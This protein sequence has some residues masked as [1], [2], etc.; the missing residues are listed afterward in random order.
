MIHVLPQPDELDRGYLGR[1]MRWNGFQKQKDFIDYLASYF[2]AR[3]ASRREVPLVLLLSRL[4]GSSVSNFVKQHTTMPFR[5]GITSYQPDLEHGSEQSRSMLSMSAMRIARPGAYFCMHCVQTDL[6]RT[7]VTYWRRSWQLP[8]HFICLQHQEP[9]HYVGHE[10]AFLASPADYLFE[11][12]QVPAAWMAFL[13]TT[14]AIQRFIDIADYLMKRPN[15]LDVRDVSCVL[16]VQ[17]DMYGLQTYVGSVKQSLLS[18]L[19]ASQFDQ[20]WLQE[21]FHELLGKEEGNWFDPIDGVLCKKTSASS[22]IAYVLAAAVLYPD[23]RLA[24]DALA[25]AKSAASTLRRGKRKVVLNAIRLREAYIEERGNH[26]GVAQ[27]F[28]SVAVPTVTGRLNELGLPNL[29]Q[30][31]SRNQKLFNGLMA[32]LLGGCPLSEAAENAGVSVSVLETLLRRSSVGL[33]QALQAMPV[34]PAEVGDNLP[35]QSVARTQLEKNSRQK[36]STGKRSSYR[37]IRRESLLLNA[38]TAS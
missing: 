1:A 16:K 38:S 24:I 21:V 19:V 13:Q 12:Q 34:M 25:N 33:L 8:G 30:N 7:G 31:I 14:P 3:D 6:A 26:A 10:R 17:A 4:A 22:V 9:L 20:A 15:A 27:Y 36:S 18:D 23:A 2:D 11:S 35:N 28:P 32:F 37:A 5:R 29:Y